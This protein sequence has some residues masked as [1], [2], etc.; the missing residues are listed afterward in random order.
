MNFK[1]GFSNFLKW[2]VTEQPTLARLTLNKSLKKAVCRLRPGNILEIGAGEY[3]THSAYLSDDC[4]YFSLNLAVSEK[5]AVAGDARLMPFSDSSFDG[6]IVLEVLEHIATP[7]LLI[8]EIRRVLKAG[9]I[10]IGSTR[11]MYPQHGA[12]NDYYR[13]TAE[14]LELL[15]REY[16]ECRIEKLGNRLHVLSDIVTENYHFLRIFNRLIQY[17]QLKPTTC[18]SGLLFVA[19]K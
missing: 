11:F 13:F 15:F 17:I 16:G 12:P 8:K 4:R 9:G 7:D 2:C 6:I 5:P 1:I 10:M 14:S 18:Y 19:N 3:N